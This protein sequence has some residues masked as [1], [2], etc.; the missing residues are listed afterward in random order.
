MGQMGSRMAR[1]LIDAG[2]G[3]TV[4]NRT[5]QRMEPLVEA[6]ARGASSPREA[7]AGA[8]MAITM[9]EGGPAVEQVIFGGVTLEAWPAGAVLVDMSSIPPDMAREHGRKLG[10]SGIDY[11]DAP[12]SG[13]T[14]GAAEG[15]LAIMGGG[16]A[17]V[18]ERCRPMFEVL[19]RVTHVGPHGSGQLAKLCNQ[20][21]VAIGIGAVSEALLLAQAGG[22]LPGAVHQALQGGFADSRILREHGQR[23]L[24]RDWRPGGATR[25]QVKDLDAVAAVAQTR[26]LTLPVMEEVR[27]LFRDFQDRGGGD[28][29]HAALLLEL[30]RLNAPHRVGEARAR[31]PDGLSDGGEGVGG[32]SG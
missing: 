10:A 16:E 12:V 14:T 19:G 24:K 5:Q 9:L 18:L 31:N 15:T 4:W 7:V 25:H 28:H 8:G 29:D 30:E 17:S 3:V 2:H 20:V 27:R 22:A 21:I 26:G 6:G 23:M 11:L 1:R 13:G 32:F